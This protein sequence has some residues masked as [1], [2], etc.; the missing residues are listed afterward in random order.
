MKTS[1]IIRIIIFSLVIVILASIMIAGMTL[2]GIRFHFG[3]DG[4]QG[5]TV[6]SEGSVPA[7]EI[8]SIA[9]EWVS[10]SITIQ[11]ADTDTITFSETG[12][13][14]K[15]EI[16]VWKQSGDEL[17][18]Q[19][20]QPRVWFGFSFGLDADNSKDLVITVPEDWNARDLHIESVS[21][22]IRANGITAGSFD[23]ENVSGY[24]DLA[25]CIIDELDVET[26]SGRVDLMGSV[27]I[28]SLEAVSADC[29]LTLSA[30]TKEIDLDSVSGDL[31]VYL[32]ADQGFTASID[33]LSGDISTDFPTTTS[34]G[35]HIHG[36]GSCKIEAE[37]V[38]GN[39][40]IWKRAPM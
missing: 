11:T 13:D 20:Q 32:P 35:T 31:T 29:T 23:I 27:R 4:I 40:S 7:G 15:E 26:V 6:S 5:G 22:D 14:S 25:E 2:Q 19:F 36:D 33:G 30:G 34:A 24:C 1:A 17:K 39:I 37:G 38:S 28:A 3:N 18:I 21:A 8:R 9:V 10:G 12:A 16:M